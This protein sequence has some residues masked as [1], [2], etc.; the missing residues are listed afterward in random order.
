[1]YSICLKRHMDSTAE[2]MCETKK[3]QSVAT[4]TLSVSCLVLKQR[5]TTQCFL[6][7]ETRKTTYRLLK[8][9]GWKIT[10]KK[11][12]VM[13]TLDLD[14]YHLYFCSR[15][16]FS[17]TWKYEVKQN[18]LHFLYFIGFFGNSQNIRRKNG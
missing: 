3:G 10:W 15:L 13:H 1:M 16:L 17:L 4:D 18:M 7:Q 9:V 2:K 14:D 6:S 12:S 8:G 5:A 11:M